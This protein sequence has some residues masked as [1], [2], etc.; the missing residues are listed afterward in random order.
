MNVTAIIVN[1][2][3]FEKDPVISS[4][5]K[6]QCPGRVKLRG[7][8]GV[9]VNSSAALSHCLMFHVEIHHSME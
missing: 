6:P 4:L 8:A 2:D 9:T 7:A 1:N 3:R 5:L